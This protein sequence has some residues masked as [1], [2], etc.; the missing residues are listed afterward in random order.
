MGQRDINRGPYAEEKCVKD[1][2]EVTSSNGVDH[3][4]GAQN[5]LDKMLP[6][7]EALPHKRS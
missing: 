1:T 4:L 5:K 7:Q 3:D 6:Y 2:E